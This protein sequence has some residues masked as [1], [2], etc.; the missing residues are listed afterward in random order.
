M[1][2][3]V[4]PEILDQLAANDPEALRS[5][6]DLKRLNWWM[7]N[8]TH[9]A[10]AITV[11]PRPPQTILEIGAGDGTFTLNLLHRIQSTAPR[12][13][14]TLLDMKPA[15]AAA[16]LNAFG[17]L[18]WQ[19]ELVTADLHEWLQQGG[20]TFDLIFANLFLH[21]LDD[22][23]LRRIF[24]TCAQRCRAFIACEPRRWLPSIISTRLLWAIGCSPVTMHDGYASVRAGFRD[25]ELTHLWPANSPFT[26]HESDPGWASHLFT[27]THK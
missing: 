8:Q 4:E 17:N 25:L 1:H 15:I 22:P 21:H 16:T 12:G 27:A 26:T 20:E 5:R 3:V 7:R 13:R 23:T 9:V 11:L 10:R 14:I 24:A 2:R 6:R 19:P 18:G